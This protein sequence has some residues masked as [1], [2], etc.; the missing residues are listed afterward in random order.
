[1]ERRFF[2]ASALAWVAAA[3]SKQDPTSGAA[4]SGPTLTSPTMETLVAPETTTTTI[5]PE[6]VDRLEVEPIELGSDPFVLGVASGDPTSSSVMLWTRLL[7]ELPQ[8][9]PL[10]WEVAL[11]E[12]FA[13]IIATGRATANDGAGHS[14]RVDVDGLPSSARLHYRF[15]AGVYI[16]SAGRTRTFVAAGL[17]ASSLRLAVSSCQRSGD[18]AYAAHRS[19]AAAD[20][21]A[22][23]WLGD[24]VYGPAKTV[25][26]YRRQYADYRR[27]PDLQA[28]HAAHPWIMIWDD[29]EVYDDFD[30]TADRGRL[31][32]GLGVWRENQPVRMPEPDSNGLVGYRSFVAGD[33][34]KIVMLDARQYSGPRSILGPTQMD[35][36]IAELDHEAAWSVIGSP[37]LASG[38][39]TPADTALLPYTWDGAPD[40]RARLAVALAAQDA[41]LVSGDLHTSMVLDFTADPAAIAAEPVAPEF[42][43]P[44]IS[45]GFP[46]EYATAAPLLELFNDHLRYLRVA[47]GWLLL[48]I[49]IDRVIGTFQFVSDVNDPSSPVVSGP[50]YEVR[51]GESSAG[52]IL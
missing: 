10:V 9:V 13:S 35:W 36:L 45:S 17:A 32:T 8:Q 24:Y 5:P 34:C 29:H 6:T 20:V 48:D 43:A 16:S 2:L 28:A 11:D 18:G 22:V 15:L 44:A 23:V 51:T 39:V 52:E 12:G 19:I 7:G 42:M 27:D 46:E 38:I 14:V 33:L 1:M 25:E 37:V 31:T 4:T 30:A 50:S 26:E 41:V 3:C 47:N 49:T 21:D 40:D